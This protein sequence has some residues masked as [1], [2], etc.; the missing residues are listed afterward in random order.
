[1]EIGRDGGVDGYQWVDLYKT[2]PAAFN[3]Q[4][5]RLSFCRSR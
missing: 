2:K 5:V 3:G 4:P 1:M